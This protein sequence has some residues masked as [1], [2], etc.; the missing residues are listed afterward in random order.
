MWNS[1]SVETYI[2]RESIWKLDRLLLSDSLW[3]LLCRQCKRFGED[4][5]SFETVGRNEIGEQ[6]YKEVQYLHDKSEHFDRL[7]EVGQ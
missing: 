6:K 7:L 2:F 1:E 3:W 5:Y 4:G